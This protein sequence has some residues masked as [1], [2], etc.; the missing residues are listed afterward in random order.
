VEKKLLAV[1]IFA[2]LL[3]GCATTNESTTRDRSLDEGVLVTGSRI[4]QKTTGTAPVGQVGAEDWRRDT[5]GKQVNPSG[6]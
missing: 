3:G 6:K 5:T 4:P 1:S 2:G